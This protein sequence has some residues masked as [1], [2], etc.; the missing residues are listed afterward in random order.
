MRKAGDYQGLPSG[1]SYRENDIFIPESKVPDST[2]PHLLVRL[3]ED[4]KEICTDTNSHRQMKCDTKIEPFAF[5]K[6]SIKRSDNKFVRAYVQVH[7]EVTVVDAGGE[8]TRP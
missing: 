3:H 1:C 4:G 6:G 7:D 2:A 8:P 5:I